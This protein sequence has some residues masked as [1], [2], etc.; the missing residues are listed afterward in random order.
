MQVSLAWRGLFV[1][2]GG[3]CDEDVEINRRIGQHGAA[4]FPPWAAVLHR[5][6]TGALATVDHGTALRIIR[7]AHEQGL[8]IHVLADETQP[9]GGGQGHG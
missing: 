4:L 3:G 5:C 2:K 6:N 8:Q 7:A 1:C 9:V